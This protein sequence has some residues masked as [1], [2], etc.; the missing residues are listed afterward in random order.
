MQLHGET[1]SLGGRVSKVLRVAVLSV[2]PPGDDRIGYRCECSAAF[3]TMHRVTRVPTLALTIIQTIM[4][5]L[6]Y[7]Y[8]IMIWCKK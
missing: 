3:V 7:S 1:Q 2:L 4:T 6:Y 5:F 8:Y